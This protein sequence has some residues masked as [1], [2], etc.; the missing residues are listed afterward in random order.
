[1]TRRHRVA[2]QKCV[3]EYLSN[4]IFALGRCP[5]RASAE[6]QQFQQRMASQASG[7]DV[8]QLQREYVEEMM[9]TPDCS[10]LAAGNPFKLELCDP[11][12]LQSWG[13]TS[14]IP[15]CPVTCG[16]A[17]GTAADM[18]GLCPPSCAA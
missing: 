6:V 3:C 7:Q 18:H 13:F 2:K 11:T 15:Y 14:L 16:C 4:T 9:E 8:I 12:S 10:R 17:D 1:M 5:L